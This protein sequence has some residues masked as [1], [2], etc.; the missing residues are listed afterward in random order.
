LGCTSRAVA[1]MHKMDS[2]LNKD[3]IAQPTTK[4]SP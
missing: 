4:N 1:D 3:R 2:A